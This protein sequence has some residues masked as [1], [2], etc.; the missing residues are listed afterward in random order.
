ML[1]QI[2]AVTRPHRVSE[3]WRVPEES[4]ERKRVLLTFHNAITIPTSVRFAKCH[5]VITLVHIFHPVQI[6]PL[7][8]LRLITFFYNTPSGKTKSVHANAIACS[9]WW[10]EIVGDRNRV[11]KDKWLMG[12]W[13]FPDRFLSA[14]CEFRSMFTPMGYLTKEVYTN[15]C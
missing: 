8:N 5:R 9:V 4:T 15:L 14:H 10:Q 2:Y 6:C 1:N 13:K 11:T 7:Q 12:R 3:W